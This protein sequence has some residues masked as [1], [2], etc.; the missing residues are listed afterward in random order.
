MSFLH[1]AHP[2]WNQT[3][4]G[5]LSPSSASATHG[6]LG[7]GKQDAFVGDPLRDPHLGKRPR[8]GDDIVAIK[9]W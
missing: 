3:Y 2:L 9:M 4:V 8:D 7:C 6:A 1:Q 5:A